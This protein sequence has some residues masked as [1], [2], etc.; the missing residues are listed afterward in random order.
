MQRERRQA[1]GKVHPQP[2]RLL[3]LRAYET[4]ISN[5]DNRDDRVVIA[6]HLEPIMVKSWRITIW[7][8]YILIKRKQRSINSTLNDM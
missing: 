5:V 7:F 3:D 1:H 6:V 4:L 8:D 2:M